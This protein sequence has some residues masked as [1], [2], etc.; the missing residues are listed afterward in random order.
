MIERISAAAGRDVSRETFEQLEQYVGLL[1]EES[2]AQNL[3]AKSTI[4]DVWQRHIVD[5]AQLLAHLPVGLRLDVGSGAGLPGIVL[6]I[7]S[8]EPITLV[9]PR[10]LRADFLN[11][12]ADRLGLESVKVVHDKVERVSGAFAAITA[13]AVASIDKLFASAHHLSHPETVWV[14]PKGRSGELELAAAQ[15]SWQGRFRTEPSVTEGDA[16]IVV[17]SHISPKRKGRG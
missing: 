12:C 14:L 7:L 2:A 5:S 1:L 11:R 9:E 15:A 4:D 16:V 8:S 3:I 17:A 10:R 6:A 13:R